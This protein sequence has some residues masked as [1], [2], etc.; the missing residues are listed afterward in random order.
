MYTRLLNLQLDQSESIFLFGPRG[1]GKTYWIK[2]HVTNSIYINLL[3][4]STY[5]KLFNQPDSLSEFFPENY[6]DWIVID[7]VQ[8]V[9]E[10]LNEVH[11]QIES[12][13]RKFILMGSSSRSLKRKGVNLL[14]GRAI[15]YHMHPLTYDELSPDFDLKKV[16]DVGLLP[17]AHQT[18]EPHKYLESYIQTYIREEV[19]QEALTRNMAAFSRFLEV[20]S[21]SQGQMLNILNIARE[22]GVDRSTIANYF[23]ILDDLLIGIRLEPFTKRAKRDVKMHPKFYFFDVGVYRTIR[24]SGYLDSPEEADGAG[25]ETLFLQSV[26]A[27]NDYDNLG[28]ELYFWHTV[29]DIEVDFILYGKKGLFA[30]E[31]KRSRRIDKSMLKGL[32]TFKKDFPEAKCYLVYTG[33]EQLFIGNITIMPIIDLLKN[34]RKILRSE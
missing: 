11:D 5:Q 22:V 15:Q 29:T 24:P 28:Y 18:P 3:K 13:G 4:F 2:K 17:K 32:E 33:N 10:L 25:L 6:Q 9:P 16:L 26:R 27:I 30:F 34:L 21:F 8:R 14:A 31:I 20:A 12:H 23:D 19:F 7:E 1:T